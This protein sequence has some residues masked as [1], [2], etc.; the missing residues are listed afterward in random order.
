[1]RNNHNNNEEKGMLDQ[2][3]GN[4]DSECLQ[5]SDYSKYD[6]EK[7]GSS[8]GRA[9]VR[10]MKLANDWTCISVKLKFGKFYDEYGRIPASGL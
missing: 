3:M 7:L 4:I 9:K 2:A 8:R 1:M 10:N 5:P 6:E